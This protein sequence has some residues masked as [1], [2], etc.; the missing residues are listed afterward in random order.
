MMTCKTCRRR[1]SEFLDGSLDVWIKKGFEEHLR[2]CP[3]CRNQVHTMQALKKTLGHLRPI[4][5]SSH[6]HFALRTRLIEELGRKKRLQS[7]FLA[8]V[9]FRRPILIAASFAL[10]V[11]LPIRLSRQNLTEERAH[12]ERI[13]THYVL[14]HISPSDR[15]ASISLDSNSNVYFTGPDTAFVPVQSVSGRIRTVSF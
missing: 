11:L 10:L 7:G 6:F 15:N 8:W 9:S 13:V 3:A 12:S 4:R 2:V 1:M 5:P 14:D